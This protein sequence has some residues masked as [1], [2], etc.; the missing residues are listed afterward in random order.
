MHIHSSLQ[1]WIV[2]LK[3]I[4]KLFE[5]SLKR[6]LLHITRYL[7]TH[8]L[9]VSVAVPLCLIA[10]GTAKIT[11]VYDMT[12]SKVIFFVSVISANILWIER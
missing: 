4:K 7:F 6:S 9:S 12:G 10:V 5:S 11:Q 1:I 8:K 2:L 3:M